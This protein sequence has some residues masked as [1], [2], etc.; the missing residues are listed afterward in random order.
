MTSPVP[1]SAGVFADQNWQSHEA[2]P[3]TS[4]S[5]RSTPLPKGSRLSLHVYNKERG[6][7]WA[8][9]EWYWAPTVFG[10]YLGTLFKGWGIAGFRRGLTSYFALELALGGEDSMLQVGAIVPFLGR[11][12]LGVRV[13]RRLLTPWIYERRVWGLR[14]GYMPGDLVEIQFGYDDAADNMAS[15]YRAKRKRGESLCWNRLTTWPGLHPTL[16]LPLGIRRYLL[17]RE[18]RRA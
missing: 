10:K 7:S 5:L 14:L 2:Q 12:H 1:K 16:R 13:P 6:P 3:P 17:Q 4:R 8:G 9:A 15:Y 11:C 18:A